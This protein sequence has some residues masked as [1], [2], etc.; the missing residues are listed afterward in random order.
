MPDSSFHG[1]Y[2]PDDVTFLLQPLAQAITVD[3]QEKERLIQSGERHY[4]EMISPE[5]QPSVA[6]MQLFERAWNSNAERTAEDALRLAIML[7]QSRQ[8]EITLVSLARAGTPFGVILKRLLNSLFQR[9]VAH[10]SISII[11]DRGIDTHALDL[12]LQAHAPGSIAFIDGWT[13]KG[14]INGELQQAIGRYNRTH[15]V[16]IDPSLWVIADLAGV[17][18]YSASASDYLIPSSILNATISGLVSRSI[19]PSD[20]EPH[21]LHGCLYFEQLKDVDV[22]LRFVEDLSSRA[23]RLFAERF[24]H[25]APPPL[26]RQPMDKAG[27]K[28]QVDALMARL[29]QTH[30]VSHINY[31]K[32]GIGESTRVLL[33]RAPGLLLLSAQARDADIAHLHRLAE[34]KNVPVTTLTDLFPYQ[35]IAIIQDV[36]HDRT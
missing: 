25:G 1:S 36:R 31:I 30:K 4:S 22:S 10:Y 27:R 8:G 21:A 17:A 35:S 3:V 28:T 7:H 12:I 26:P 33:R 6:Y 20:S 18:E 34:D 5:R 11:R 24:G 32:P 13:G 16:H 14:I 23:Q 15:A 29:M 2:P 9:Q 19:M